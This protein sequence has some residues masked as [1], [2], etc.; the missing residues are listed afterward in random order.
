MIDRETHERKTLAFAIE[1]EQLVDDLIVEIGETYKTRS[2]L[3][4]PIARSRSGDVE[5]DVI[6]GTAFVVS[7]RVYAAAARTRDPQ[8]L[9]R[10]IERKRRDA[11]RLRAEE[12][13]RW[14]RRVEETS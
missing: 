1:A 7:N 13:A 6:G 11:A 4:T 14:K 10:T 12:D 8:N 3:T 5:I 9:A 2:G